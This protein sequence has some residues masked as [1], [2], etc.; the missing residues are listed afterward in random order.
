[1]KRIKGDNMDKIEAIIFEW[2]K[3]YPKI[4]NK[5]KT[6]I[7]KGDYCYDG[8]YMCPYREMNWDLAEEVGTEQGC[9]YCH[10]LE[11]GDWDVGVPDEAP[12]GF[13][14]SA[15]SLIWDACKECGV[16]MYTAEELEEMFEAQSKE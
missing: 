6:L 9:G 3:E 16:N 15:I 11:R 2:V 1:M 7:P 12:D 10:Y 8:D 4:E 5:D 14:Q 13:P